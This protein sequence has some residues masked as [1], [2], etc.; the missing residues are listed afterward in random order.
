MEKLTEINYQKQL[1]AT[2]IE[3]EEQLIINIA[4]HP[5]KNE[6]DWCYYVSIVYV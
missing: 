1:D 4:E 6:K 3:N 2:V 5:K